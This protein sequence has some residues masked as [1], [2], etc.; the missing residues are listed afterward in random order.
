MQGQEKGSGGGRS[1]LWSELA[2][3]I[4]EIRPT[5]AIVEN[6]PALLGPE[7]GADVVL[8]DL[9]ESGIDAEWD[10]LPAAAFGAH[11]VRDR[12]FIIP[13]HP[14]ANCLR[15]QRE[16]K[17]ENRTWSQQQ[18]E[19]LLQDQLRLAVPSGKTGG[20]SVRVPNRMERLRGL[21]NSVVPQVVEWIGRRIL[22]VSGER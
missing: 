3:V 12:I 6:V 5:Y 19:G 7:R 13:T 21:G 20:V 2:R 9:A 11:H 4:G 15:P 8:R 17:V 16:W 18:F 22:E 1:G 14:Y 10:C